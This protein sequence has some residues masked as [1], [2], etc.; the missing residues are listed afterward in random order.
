MLEELGIND[1]QVLD[2]ANVTEEGK[3]ELS[4]NAPEPGLYRLRFEQDRFLLLSIDKG[5]LKINGDWKSLEETYTVTG[6][7]P[8]TSLQV[9]L[10]TV[11]E[12]IRDFQT[13]TRG[14]CLT[15]HALGILNVYKSQ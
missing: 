12:H 1:V 6:S 7:E 3:F 11:R 4:G 8:S 15:E 10:T 14:S 5:T 9:F 2:S 13:Q